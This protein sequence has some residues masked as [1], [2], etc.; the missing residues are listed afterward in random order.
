MPGGISASRTG[1]AGSRRLT[2]SPTLLRFLEAHGAARV[3][4][5]RVETPRELDHYLSRFAAL[6]SYQV[7]YLALHGRRG[8]VYV[9]RKSSWRR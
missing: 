7:G 3:I 6:D 1:P 9:G 2:R 8:H 4:H 5:Q